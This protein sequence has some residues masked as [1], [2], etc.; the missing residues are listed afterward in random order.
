MNINTINTKQ[1]QLVQGYFKI[2]S[3]TQKILIIGSCRTVPY[4]NYFSEWNEANGNPFTVC[5][6]DPYN[7]C[8][9]LSNNRRDHSEVIL[10]MEKDE[11]MLELFAST[12]ICIHEYYRNFGMFNFDSGEA[13]NIYQF[14]MKPSIDIC[15]PNW[16]DYF[17][18]FGDIVSFDIEIRKKAIADYNVLGELSAALQE[19][20][21]DISQANLSKFYNVC[22][23]SSLPEFGPHFFSNFLKKRYFWNSN[24]VTKEFTIDV[25]KLMNKKFLNLSLGKGFYPNHIDMFSNVQTSLTTYDILWHGYEWDGELV[26]N[27]KEKL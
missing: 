14:G 16:N 7:W 21:Y 4:V 1:A 11:T 22:M 18:L 10:G 3:G 13:K 23:K 9:D 15:I 17:V 19:D 25:F 24:H 27:L 12:D 20:I 6:I 8:F 5:F 2:G 26:K